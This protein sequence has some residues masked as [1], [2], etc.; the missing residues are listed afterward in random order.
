MRRPWG[1]ALCCALLLFGSVLHSEQVAEYQVKAEF[2]E[3]FTR[4]VE[5]PS[6]AH[7]ERGN[8]FSIGVIGENPFNS[9]LTHIASDR[10]IKG[11][12]V[13]VRQVAPGE[14]LAAFDIVFISSSERKNL[15]GVLTRAGNLPVLTIG[16][17]SGFA[18]S[19]VMINFY[20][21]GDQVRFEINESAVD[22]CGLKVSSKLLALARVVGG[23]D[24]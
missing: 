17:T 7:S 8:T 14:S 22:H 3:R 15:S 21:S 24:R 6:T 4:F 12:S 10:K 23:G 20:N 13:E 18:E 16:D 5:W 9:Y 1:A 11:K 19:G 2:I